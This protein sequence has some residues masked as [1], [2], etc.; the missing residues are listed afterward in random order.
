MGQLTGISYPSGVNVGYGYS[1][2]RLGAITATFNGA[3]HTVATI[4]EYQSIDGPPTWIN[5]GNDTWRLSTLDTDRRLTRNVLSGVGVANLQDLNYAYN[6]NN[7]IVGITNALDATMTQTF[8]YDALSRLTSVQASNAN[9]TLQYD[10]SNN[11]TNHQWTLPWGAPAG[12]T[13]QVEGNSNRVTNDNIA[14]VYDGRGN[15]Q[16]QSWGG[17]TATFTYDAFNA[18]RQAS[19]DTTTPT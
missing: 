14:Y 10:A 7:E 16:V 6:A 5:Y 15:R 4:G 18:L 3:M 9:Q 8:G 13:H 19:R 2:G 1:R 12:S 17:S 11:L